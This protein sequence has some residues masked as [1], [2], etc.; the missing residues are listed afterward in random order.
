MK[1]FLI[2][3]LFPFL[4]HS[5]VYD[6]FLFYNELELLEM[7]LNEMNDKVDHFVIVE[8]AETFRGKPKTLIFKEN[9]ERF[10]KFKEKIIYIPLKKPCITDDP[11][12]R[13]GYQRD[14]MIRG[15]KNCKNDDIILISDVDEIVRS[16]KIPTTLKKNQFCVFEQTM[17]VGCLNRMHGYWKGTVALNYKDLKRIGLKKGRNL[18]NLNGRTKKKFDAYTLIENGGW[19]FSSMG[20]I[21]RYIKKLESFSHAECDTNEIKNPEAI[22]ANI[23]ANTLVEI[24]ET[25]PKY[26][27]ENQEQLKKE[28]FIEEAQ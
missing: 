15:L 7:R 12:K 11:W 10:K 27:I 4:V 1:K 14:Q 18:R 28:G 24:D 19:H 22:M 20:G 6:C 23:K 8:A 13:E 21:D 2:L 25:Y 26:V 17:Y 5:E 3:L 9:K 16:D